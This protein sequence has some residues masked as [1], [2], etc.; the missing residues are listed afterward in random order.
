MGSM[1]VGLEEQIG[2]LTKM[3]AYFA[4]RAEGGVGLIVTGGVAPNIDGW[5]KPFAAKLSN[6][7]EAYKHRRGHGRRARRGRKDRHADPAHGPLR[8]PPA[9]RRTFCEQVPHQPLPARGLSAKGVERTIRD[10]VDCAKHAQDAGYDGVVIM[11]SEGYLINQFIAAKTNKRKD[12]WGGS[13]EQRIQFPIEIVRRT[14]EAVGDAFILIYRLSML[15]LVEDGSTWEEVVHLAKEIEAAGAS[16]INTGIGWHEARV[17]TIATM[18]PRA[19]FSWVTRRLK[20]E[21]SIPLITSNRIHM[22]HVAEEI[23]ATGDAD[24]VTLA[25]PFLADP[26]WVNKAAAGREKAIN[27]C[28]ACNQ[29]CLD[30]IFKNKRASCLVNPL[31]CYETELKIHPVAQRRKIAVVGAGPAGLAA[32][33]TAAERGHDVVLYEAASE[34]GGQFN[35]AKKVPGK[36]EFVETLRYF[37][38]RLEET[39]VRVELNRKVQATDLIEEG[40]DAVLLATGVSARQLKLPGIDHPKVV[41]YIDVLRDEVE[42]GQRVAIIGAG[43]IGFDVAEF[44]AHHGPSSSLDIGAYAAQWGIDQELA[45]RG[46]LVKPEHPE[47]ARQITMCQRS[48]GKLGAKLGKTTGWS[49]G[50]ASSNSTSRC[51][52]RC[53]TSASTTRVCTS[54]WPGNRGCWRSTMSSSAPARCRCARSRARSRAAAWRCTS[55]AARTRL[56]SSTPSVPSTKPRDWPPRSSRLECPNELIVPPVLGPH[57]LE[58]AK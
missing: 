57:R 5:A 24:M 55:S 56:P 38:H 7:W 18:V 26:D 17:P 20:G 1:H 52:I 6:R 36:E 37:N 22:P 32:A 25:R 47:P 8:L 43:G 29:A 15:D 23:L 2:P 40:Y 3:A 50:P 54:P 11:G 34:I 42:V 53:S 13:Y 21:V 19:G 49:T 41:S 16:I 45:S 9:G 39:G 4:R 27:T 33:T 35:M 48:Q 51:S 58:E 44:L 14:R 31:A 10:F 46:G 28:I 30:H 12:K